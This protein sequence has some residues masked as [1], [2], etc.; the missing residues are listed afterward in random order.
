[1]LLG[2]VVTALGAGVH[3]AGG[4][5]IA[6][7]AVVVIFEE[8]GRGPSHL[9]GEVIA[10]LAVVTIYEKKGRGPSLETK[11]WIQVTLIQLLLQIMPSIRLN[12]RPKKASDD[13]I[14]IQDQTE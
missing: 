11:V 14:L 10:V 6:L 7:Q 1:M 4:E 8:K 12:Q 5:V 9:A 2:E 13:V 3:L